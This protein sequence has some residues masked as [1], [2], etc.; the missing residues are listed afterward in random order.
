MDHKTTLSKTWGN[1]CVG[2][3]W[4]MWVRSQHSLG[5]HP[6]LLISGASYSKVTISENG[7]SE[8]PVGLFP[9]GTLKTK[10]L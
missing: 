5:L 1:E 7:T 2:P 10:G 6:V 9:G 4:G 8:V 3:E